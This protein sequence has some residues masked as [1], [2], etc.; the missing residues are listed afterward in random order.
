MGTISRTVRVL[1]TYQLVHICM[2]VFFFLLDIRIC[3][4]VPSKIKHSRINLSV[5]SALK[6]VR[7]CMLVP[8][9]YPEVCVLASSK[10]K[11]IWVLVQP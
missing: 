7:I 3:V 4:L 11:P 8:S 1:V 6:L 10:I 5:S 2:L 9:A